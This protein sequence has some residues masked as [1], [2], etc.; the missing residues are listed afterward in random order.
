[1]QEALATI[2]LRK[3]PEPPATPA[4][5]APT[6][7]P[8]AA[9]GPTPAAPVATPAPPVPTPAPTAAE[10]PAAS[11]EGHIAAS[12]EVRTSRLVPL[13]A[14]VGTAATGGLLVLGAGGAI[15]EAARADEEHKTVEAIGYSA[16]ATGGLLGLIT[17]ASGVAASDTAV[18]ALG[19]GIA[20][21]SSLP[22]AFVAA[23]WPG[24][25]Y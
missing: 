3:P 4:P 24:S 14:A 16:T 11:A 5:P 9:A 1:M 21:W 19:L 18:A 22:S 15:V 20:T 6:P 12:A 17:W 13:R 23:L 25:A 10:A 7:A 2:P 8:T